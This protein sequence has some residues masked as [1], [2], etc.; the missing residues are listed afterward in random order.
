MV[1]RPAYRARASPIYRYRASCPCL[2]HCCHRDRPRLNCRCRSDLMRRPSSCWALPAGFP[3]SRRDRLS[4]NRAH[5]GRRSARAQLTDC[6]TARSRGLPNTSSRDLPAEQGSLLGTASA[7]GTE[8]VLALV[9]AGVAG[10]RYE[11]AGPGLVPKS[12]P[13]VMRP[14]DRSPTA[15]R[16][17][18]SIICCASVRVSCSRICWERSFHRRDA[19]VPRC[20]S[21]I[22]SG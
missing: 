5:L 22:G 15:L 11:L 10:T 20:A 13:G 8:T 7:E 4:W 1:G 6:P 21:V 3:N 9:Y 16:R 14:Y 18:S 17:S 12:I 19:R 2:G